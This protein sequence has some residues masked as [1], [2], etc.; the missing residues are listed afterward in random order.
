MVRLFW[1]EI[2]QA[3]GS[4]ILRYYYAAKL[5][6]SLDDIDFSI[7]DFVNKINSD[8]LGKFINIASRLGRFE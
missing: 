8:V 7:E 1:R 4:G 2:M 3:F 5:S 6:S